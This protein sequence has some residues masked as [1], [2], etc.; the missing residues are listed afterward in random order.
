MTTLPTR[1]RAARATRGFT[2]LELVF[3]G[4]IASVLFLVLI[5]WVLT[6]GAAS[7]ATLDNAS[8]Q[9]SAD[10]ARDAFAADVVTARPCALG[11]QTALRQIAPD[12]VSFYISNDGSRPDTPVDLVQWQVDGTNLTRQLVAATDLD[13]DGIAGACEFPANFPKQAAGKSYADNITAIQS[14]RIAGGDQ[15]LRPAFY[16]VSGG[17]TVTDPA[18]AW[19]TCAQHQSAD[20][21][22]ASAIG[23]NWL[24]RSPVDGGAPI[25]VARTYQF[26]S[27]G[28]GLS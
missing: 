1:L 9:R 22:Y 24:F 6:L 23:L 28:E 15:S 12:R 2:L 7:S 13:G 14:D 11:E 19:G 27:T 26:S 5:R 18:Q 4:L 10:V 21:C 20:R 17:Q 25:A 8:A 3:V 16:T